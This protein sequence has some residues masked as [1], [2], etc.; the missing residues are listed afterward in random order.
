MYCGI[1]TR[2]IMRYLTLDTECTCLKLHPKK[3]NGSPFARKNSL[4]YVGLRTDD[5][6]YL[7]FPIEYQDRGYG[8][9]L[10]LIQELINEHDCLIGFN[11]KF[12]LHWLR[13][14]GINF[15][16]KRVF[17]CQL[18]EFILSN[19]SCPYPSLDVTAEFYGLEGKLDV[20][21][22]EY[23]NLGIDTD[24]IPEDVLTPY[25]KQDVMTTWEVFKQQ[26]TRITYDNRVLFSL[27]NQ[28]LIALEEI[29]Y[30][31]MLYNTQLSVE[32]GDAIQIDLDLLDVEMRTFLDTPEFKPSSNDHV[33]AALYGGVIKWP[34][35]E[36][37]TFTYKDGRTAGKTRN[38]IV[39]KVM[40]RLV[41]PLKGSE[42][43]KE[44]YFATNEPTLSSLR[45]VGATKKFIA[46]LMERSGLEK[47]RGTYLHGLPEMMKE[48][49]WDENMIHGQFN[50]C[51]AITGRLSSSKPNQQN[52]D[53]AINNL[54]ISRYTE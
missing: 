39:E 10:K 38:I 42:L 8:Q 12:D 49:D 33:S 20:V 51:V 9:N 28:D 24:E 11:L 1:T 6:E 17:D 36:I 16:S 22:E 47:R 21:K 4:T 53:K 7:D 45:T 26:Q 54:F 14:Y 15:Q 32:L 13:R 40:P 27:A 18:A 29:E 2:R 25:L 31:G 23:W 35:K 34:D 44:G 46:M 30:N 48:M 37:Y 52:M 5:G 19:Q 3:L 43:A 41:S 50:Q